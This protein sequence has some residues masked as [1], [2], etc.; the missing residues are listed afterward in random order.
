MAKALVADSTAR[1]IVVQTDAYIATFNT[2]GAVLKSYRLRHYSDAKGEP[3]ELLPTDLPVGAFPRPFTISTD[4]AQES[5]TLAAALYLPSAESLSLG[6]SPGTLTFEYRDESGLNARKAFYFQPKG[7][8]YVLNVEGSVDVSGK[9]RAVTVAFG[10]GLGLGYSPDGQRLTAARGLQYLNGS[11]QRLTAGDVQKQL[12]HE[13]AFRYAGVDDHYFIAVALLAD[14]AARADY[15]PVTVPVPGGAD[16]ATRSFIAFS[17]RPD[18][19][20][21]PSKTVTVPF[22]IGRKTSTNSTPPT[23]NWCAPSISGCSRS[24]SC[25]C[26]RR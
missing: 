4:N 17:V 18:P 23:P 12:R 11:V 19:G 3:L 16:G 21:A 26:C 25:R 15:A 9:P 20:A 1:D 14:A 6:S 2:Q 24:S 22:F 10:P 7:Q 8:A 13:G 5:A